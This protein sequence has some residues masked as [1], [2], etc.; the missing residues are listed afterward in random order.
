MALQCGVSSLAF[1][2]LQR[3]MPYIRIVNYHGT[4]LTEADLFEK[5]LRRYREIFVPATRADL[6]TLL[7]CEPWSH[8]KPGLIITFDDGLRSNFDVAAPLLERY[9]FSGWF[10]IPTN[11][12]EALPENQAAFAEHHRIVFSEMPSD[13]RLAMSWDE[14]RALTRKHHVGCHTATH[15]RMVETT[16]ADQLGAEIIGSK[17]KL[18]A[19]LGE[20]VDS[21]CWVG[22]EENTYSS[23]AAAHVRA[24]GYKY[25][26]MTNCAVVRPNTSCYQLQRTNIEAGWSLEVVDFQLSGLL[27]LVYWPKR[28]RVNRLTRGLPAGPGN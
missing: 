6:A 14:A 26:F 17:Q 3:A 5:Q 19:R 16:S 9:G 24:A 23:A 18:E 11:F 15:H 21:F 12:I 13:R 2:C 7:D 20:P 25:G 8:E 4:P 27:D 22:G 10:F 1:H 28:T